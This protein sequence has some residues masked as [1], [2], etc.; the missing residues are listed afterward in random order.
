M[1]LHEEEDEE[2][3]DEESVKTIFTYLIRHF[4][5]ISACSYILHLEIET[6]RKFPC[7]LASGAS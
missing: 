1:L 3:E 4:L 5:P 2:E 6:E 7:L